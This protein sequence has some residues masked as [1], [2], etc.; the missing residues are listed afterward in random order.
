MK[1]TRLQKKGLFPNK[2]G[3]LGDIGQTISQTI[4]NLLDITPKPIKIILFIFL[5]LAFAQLFTYAFN[6]F[7]I[8][9]NSN[10]EPVK[11]HTNIID[12]I[13][14]IGEIPD[15]K[16]LG[17]NAIP[18]EEAGFTVA[19]QQVTAC[20]RQFPSGTIE[21]ENGT[22]TTFT[23][24]RWFYDGT[25]CTECNKVS[26]CGISGDCNNFCETDV[27]RITEEQKG[28]FQKAFCGRVGCEPPEHYYYDATR[29]IYI[30]LDN[31]C[32]A[33][34]IA[35]LWDNKLASKGATT[36]YQGTQGNQNPAYTN[37]AGI[38]CLEIQPRLAVF[39]IDVFSFT[40]WIFLI[41]I[42]GLA[43]AYFNFFR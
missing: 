12:Q 29:N 36:L 20:S 4:G 32:Q 10:N 22:Q 34:T 40:L 8:Y 39:G 38:T 9:C 16:T 6:M 18:T 23:Q 13:A 26:V 11:I 3:L 43:W 33:T 5:L 21:T 15:Y 19:S 25:F 30:C 28:F 24:S 1:K 42:F 7:G 2:K 35:T 31:T 41:I 27:T 14:L 37:F 17:L